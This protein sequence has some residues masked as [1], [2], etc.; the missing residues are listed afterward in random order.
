[1]PSEDRTNAAGHNALE[2]VCGLGHRLPIAQGELFE[3]DR[4]YFCCDSRDCPYKTIQNKNKYCLFAEE[5]HKNKP[6]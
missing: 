1:M 3:N 5:P 6:V 4:R 2:P